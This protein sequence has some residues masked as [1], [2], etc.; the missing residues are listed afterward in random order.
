MLNAHN[1]KRKYVTQVSNK[2]LSQLPPLANNSIGINKHSLILKRRHKLLN[3]VS[4]YLHHSLRPQGKTS[5]RNT[6]CCFYASVG[7]SVSWH[8]KFFFV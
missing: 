7:F 1:V 6:V 2:L 3:D 5:G 8:F 4:N